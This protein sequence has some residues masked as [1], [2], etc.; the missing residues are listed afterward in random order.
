MPKSKNRKGHKAKKEAYKMK[1]KQDQER[2]RKV[3]H[4]QYVKSKDDYLAS[5]EMH[6]DS[7]EQ[8]I[9]IDTGDFG[10]NEEVVVDT[11]KDIDID[12]DDI[13]IV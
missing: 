7:E 8:E 9:D 13:E 4:E 1:V 3:M 12:I 2:M 6:K 11:N 5:Q 10:M